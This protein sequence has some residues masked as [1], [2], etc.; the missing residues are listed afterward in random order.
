APA[1]PQW[2]PTPEGSVPTPGTWGAGRL[3]QRP[4]T[5]AGGGGPAGGRA[6]TPGAARVAQRREEGLLSLPHRLWE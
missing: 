6:S 1:P 3:R 5:S 2:A 4:G